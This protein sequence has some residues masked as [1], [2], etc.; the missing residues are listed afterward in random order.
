MG[1]ETSQGRE[2]EDNARWLN[3]RYDYH[4]TDITEDKEDRRFRKLEP[5]IDK[6]I[7]NSPSSSHERFIYFL[8]ITDEMEYEIAEK[9]GLSR[10]SFSQMKKRKS[11]PNKQTLLLLE[12]IYNLNPEWLL[13]GHGEMF[14]TKNQNVVPS[15]KDF[16]ALEKLVHHQNN[17]IAGLAF[18]VDKLKI[19]QGM[20]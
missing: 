17:V 8:T 2:K 10:S 5:K 18:E 6:T 9:L 3:A 7:I 13:V 19:A 11:D 1:R 4:E 12:L 20:K 14:L 16:L 15:S